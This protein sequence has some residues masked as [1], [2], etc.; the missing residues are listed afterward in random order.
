MLPMDAQSAHP[1]VLIRSEVMRIT[2]RDGSALHSDKENRFEAVDRSRVFET[3]VDCSPRWRAANQPQEL[4]VAASVFGRLR[5]AATVHP[6]C[7][8]ARG[9]GPR[10]YIQSSPPIHYAGSYDIKELTRTTDS[11]YSF[12]KFE[13][14][15]ENKSENRRSRR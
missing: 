13:F 14:C 11:P 12:P 5:A 4:P 1:W 8:P 7:T 6:A 2:S 3:F 15:K 10:V 9:C